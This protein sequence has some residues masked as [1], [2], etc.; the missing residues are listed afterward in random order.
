[1]TTF[2]QAEHSK[3]VGGRRGLGWAGLGKRNQKNWI[4]NMRDMDEERRSFE[5]T[6]RHVV[7][8][9][10]SVIEPSGGNSRIIWRLA[11]R[12]LACHLNE[13]S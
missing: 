3:G 7:A 4:S 2:G 10:F 13:M 1:M 11:N 6:K 9:L 12:I 8:L 5:K